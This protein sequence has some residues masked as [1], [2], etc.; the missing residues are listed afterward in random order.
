MQTITNKSLIE[1]NARIGRFASLLGLLILGAGLY[2]S[3]RIPERFGLS[4][5]ALLVGFALSQIGIYFGNRWARSPRPDE[6]LNKA[7]K[8]LSRNY[9]LYHYSGPVSHLLIGPA[10]VWVLHPLHQRG[11]ITYER[12]RLRQRGGG[13]RLFYLK[14]FA[15]EGIGRPLLELESE[16]ERMQRFLETHAPEDGDLPTLKGALVFT[17]EE[18]EIDVEDAPHPVLAARELKNVIRQSAKETHFPKE[19]SGRLNELLEE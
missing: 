16:L 14:I 5:G 4:L 9:S 11:K 10:G 2:I 6:L 13:L 12:G 17:N 15:Q 7:L 19:E 3:Y 8:G 1:R 18:A